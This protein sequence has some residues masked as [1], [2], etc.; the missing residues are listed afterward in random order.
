MLFCNSALQ[1]C[2]NKSHNVSSANAWGTFALEALNVAM[3]DLMSFLPCEILS[4]YSKCLLCS[5]T[6][7][8]AAVRADT[9]SLHVP[10]AGKLPEAIRLN[11][12]FHQSMAF[13]LKN[14]VATS[15]D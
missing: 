12:H 3:Y 11:C 13:P 9:K 5:S 14:I 8:K 1:P 7:L 10:K 2:R 15:T 6:G 4:N